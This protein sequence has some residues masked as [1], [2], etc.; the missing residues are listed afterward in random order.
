MQKAY[1]NPEDLRWVM[2]QW[3]EDIVTRTVQVEVPKPDKFGGC[4]VQTKPEPVIIE[5]F[6]QYAKISHSIF[7]RWLNGNEANDEY[8][9]LAH[10]LKD[11]CVGHT[12]RNGFLGYATDKMSMFYLVNN[13]RYKDVSEVI[14]ENTTKVLPAWMQGASIEISSKEKPK[15][16]PHESINF[17]DITNSGQAVSIN[18]TKAIQTP[19]DYD[20]L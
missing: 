8:R 13:S 1:P 15:G 5:S 14:T 7:L 9:R 4:I 11:F 19:D 17:I 12:I 18:D 2:E 20:F 10:D 16:L 6:C 3:K